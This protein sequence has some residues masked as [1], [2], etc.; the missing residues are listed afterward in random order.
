[1]SNTALCSEATS[2]AKKATRHA[3]TDRLAVRIGGHI[4]VARRAKR[5]TVDALAAQTNLR[6]DR[7]RS[8]EAGTEQIRPDELYDISQALRRKISYFFA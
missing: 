7:V 6:P 2:L 3:I 8:L 5:L 1:M 4:R